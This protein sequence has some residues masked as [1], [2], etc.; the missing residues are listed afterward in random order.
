MTNGHKA[1]FYEDKIT[2]SEDGLIMLTTTAVCNHKTFNDEQEFFRQYEGGNCECRNLIFNC[3]CHYLICFEGDL[4]WGGED[5]W[6]EVKDGVNPHAFESF[7]KP[8]EEELAIVAEKYPDFAKV[9]KKSKLYSR[10]NLMDKL[11]AWLRNRD[12][13][14]WL[15]YGLENIA[16]C[17]EIYK[18]KSAQK[19]VKK[20]VSAVPKKS[21]SHWSVKDFRTVDTLVTVFGM[22]KKTAV[23]KKYNRTFFCNWIKEKFSE[24]YNILF[25]MFDGEYWFSN[26]VGLLDVSD[27]ISLYKSYVSDPL[28]FKELAEYK[29]EFFVLKGARFNKIRRN[30]SFKY[31]LKK[32]KCNTQK[33]FDMAFLSWQSHKEC[34]YLLASGFEKLATEDTMH[35]FALD[36]KKKV[37]NALKIMTENI[38]FYSRAL[39]SA[40][41]VKILCRLLDVGFEND[42]AVELSDSKWG[43]FSG[44]TPVFY[45]WKKRQWENYECDI[46]YHEYIRYLEDCQR[47]GHDTDNDYWK[48]PKNFKRKVRYVEREIEKIEEME[49]EE[50]NKKKSVLLSALNKD[51][52]QKFIDGFA[53]YVPTDCNQIIRQAETLHQCLVSCDYASKCIKRERILVFMENEN[54]MPVAT[55]EICKGGIIGQFYTNELDRNNCLP[56]AEM[57]DA[58]NK[59]VNMQRNHID[60]F[61]AKKVA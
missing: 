18:S 14:I 51:F 45:S 26:I 3:M 44:M 33:L 25:N 34:E 46:T 41:R 10:L 15:S 50:K 47:V 49:E 48:M 1:S 7:E 59:Y 32:W 24:F 28:L 58:M 9:L 56:T 20:Y 23:E 8:T 42:Q 13:K 35:F 38:S 60:D 52:E 54:G 55:A 36:D 5:S 31:V 11:N 40:E 4:Y 19:I 22:D 2:L 39:V 27:W 53:V 16:F 43:T 21:R 30:P 12:A 61:F 17:K 6:A 57:K 29:V 37:L